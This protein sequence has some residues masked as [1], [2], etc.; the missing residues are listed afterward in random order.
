ME[1][2]AHRIV[3]RRGRLRLQAVV[4]EVHWRRGRVSVYGE[5]FRFSAPKAIVTLPLGVLQSSAVRFT[6]AI[7]KE[8]AFKGLIAGPVIKAA[9]RFP[10]AFWEKGHPGV[11]F[12]HSQRAAFP[13]FWTPLPAR[14]PLL[15]A[16]AGGPKAQRISPK[17]TLGAIE[18]SLKSIFPRIPDPDAVYLHDWRR[19]PFARGAYSYVRVNG[20][21]AREALQRPLVDTLFFAGEATNLEGESGTVSG[22]LQSGLRA[23]R[24]A[25]G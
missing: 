23:A 14:V 1:W 6:P 21:G 8:G 25:I 10:T 13:T 11:A 2:L 5:G 9:L 15:I 3:A 24:E 17:E 22:A 18:A 16:W 12:F 20:A 4:R 19:D 7:E